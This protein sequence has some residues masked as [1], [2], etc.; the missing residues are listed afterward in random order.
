MNMVNAKMIPQMLSAEQTELTKEICSDILQS[1]EKEPNCCSSVIA[2]D[3]TLIF[4]Y[5]T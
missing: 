5:D 2:C 4:T 3:A 1:T